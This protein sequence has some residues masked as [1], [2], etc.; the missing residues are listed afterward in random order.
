[1]ELVEVY[2]RLAALE[3]PRALAEGHYGPLSDEQRIYAE[4]IYEGSVK[5]RQ[6]IDDWIQLEHQPLTPDMLTTHAH[7]I[8]SG[9]TMM[10]G[11]ASLMLTGV[12]GAV[13]PEIEAAL[14]VIVGT[15]EQVH[16]VVQQNFE[17]HLNTLSTG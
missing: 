9:L 11:Y 2:H 13:L 8:N 5:A 1:M 10:L 6:W 12:G 15:G 3:E 17:Q 14:N 7:K 4:M 16:R